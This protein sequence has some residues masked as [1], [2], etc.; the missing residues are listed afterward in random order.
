MKLNYIK[1]SN[2]LSFNYFNNIDEANSIIFSNDST[3]LNIII[4]P[5]GSGKS[6]LIEI[7]NYIFTSFLY[8]QCQINRNKHDDSSPT[9]RKET[10][11]WLNNNQYLSRLQNNWYSQNER[12]DIKLSISL[13]RNDINNIKEIIQYKDVFEQLLQNYSNIKL[14]P[15]VFNNFKFNHEINDIIIHITR[16]DI[17]NNFHIEI[18]SHN[19]IKNLLLNYLQNFNLFQR[20][21]EFYNDIEDKKIKKPFTNTFAF[22]S[23]FRNYSN[24]N[25]NLSGNQNKFNLLSSINT[26]VLN[27]SSKK[28]NTNEPPAFEWVKQK[29]AFA[30]MDLLRSQG[31]QYMY[32]QIDKINIFKNINYYLFEFL[33]LSLEIEIINIEQWSFKFYFNDKNKK[34][35]FIDLGSGEQAII[36]LIFVL[37]GFDLTNGL[38]IIDEPELHLHPQFQKKYLMILENECNKENIQSIIVTH[39]PIFINEKSIQNTKRLYFDFLLNT[40][41]SISPTITETDKQLIKILNYT[42]SSKLFFVNKVILVEGETDE[43]FFR[44]YI[45]YLDRYYSKDFNINE[46]EVININGKKNYSTWKNFLKKWNIDA[47]FICDWDNVIDFKILSGSDLE[48]FKSK[49]LDEHFKK[50]K[51]K[52]KDKNSKDAKELF[53][54]LYLY[55]DD[56]DKNKLEDLR[57]LC[58]YLYKRHTP[59][60]ELI[61]IIKKSDEFLKIEK[62]IEK[63][64]EQKIY[65]LKNGELEDYIKVTKD[66]NKVIEFCNTI[67][68]E[69]VKSFIEIN[70]IISIIFNSNI[71]RH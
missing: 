13:N 69:S 45:D 51:T 57:L 64:Y 43:Y 49:L 35:P 18:L 5:N 32:K 61:S 11:K 7:L 29:L 12:Q 60:S 41:V 28:L 46:Y 20:I 62:N 17:R 67:S 10:I 31:E 24:F 47:H 25:T 9:E 4:G 30:C 54:S 71:H 38:F 70:N 3:S 48:E 33:S 42:N 68:N 36:H 26:K 23:C 19:E 59:Y 44:Y 15:N 22:I 39:S 52:L 2:I 37:F 66:L 1:I 40:T 53:K 58:E 16:V 63:L 50:I 6:N 56:L 65:I 14:S 8:K 34:V 27:I 55:L 21:I